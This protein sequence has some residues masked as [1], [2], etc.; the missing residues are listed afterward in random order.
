MAHPN[1]DPVK[2]S[3]LLKKEATAVG[4][5]LLY[6]G[7]ISFALRLDL[8]SS[9]LGCDSYD[10]DAASPIAPPILQDGSWRTNIL[11]MAANSIPR[12]LVSWR[13]R[14][15][16]S[17]FPSSF[18]YAPIEMDDHTLEPAG[19]HPNKLQVGKGSTHDMAGDFRAVGAAFK[20]TNA[21]STAIM[22][23]DGPGQSFASGI[24]LFERDEPT[25]EEL[26]TLRKV[27]DHLPWSAFIVALVE[28]CER[29]T[30]YGLSGP[31]QNYIQYHPHDTPVRGGI[32]MAF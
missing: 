24:E 29:F 28:L 22:G 16:D 21:K 4:E 19:Y 9:I 12:R 11:H 31:F 3:R 8:Y 27:S 15:L 26:A 25:E 17:L 5:D 23:E 6:T 13:K 32:G 20:S 18:E 2:D 30:Y 1:R 14:T 10:N 7:V